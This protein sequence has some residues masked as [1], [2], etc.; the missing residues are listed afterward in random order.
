MECCGL[1]RQI[2]RRLRQH[3]AFW[4]V[5]RDRALSVAGTIGVD[6]G[7]KLFNGIPGD[8]ANWSVPPWRTTQM[9]DR[10]YGR[11]T[12]DMKAAICCAI[13]AAKA[14]VD[15]GVKL[16]GRL[17]IQTVMGEEDG[18]FGTLA[19]ILGGGTAE[20][21]VVLEPDGALYRAA[22]RGAPS[23]SR[24]PPMARARRV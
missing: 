5:A 12:V 22:A 1:E 15:A 17:T 24:G 4:E 20:G 23:D 19:A 2:S 16:R 21:A 9:A 10:I 6:V 8:P 11:G 18:G 3:P 7:A 13:F 14:I